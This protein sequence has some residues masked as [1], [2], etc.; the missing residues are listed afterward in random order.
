MPSSPVSEDDGAVEAPERDLEAEIA[1]LEDRFMRARADLENYRKRAAREVERQVGEA[2]DSINRD[3]LAVV[4]SVERALNVAQPDTPLIE[5]M[6]NVL[7][8]M[9]TI[10]GRHGIVRTGA[11]GERFD[12][13]RAEAVGVIE[14]DE[15]P[16]G[17][18]V[19]VARSGYAGPDRVL[20]PA[21][22]VV[23][24]APTARAPGEGEG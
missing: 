2:R 6:R 4:D 10:L 21:Q 22:V 14:T 15:H 20:R 1:E 24:R 13:E 5:G 12:P 16:G 3:W 7:E 8:Q 11:V 9:E 19:E 23:A 18:V 17:T